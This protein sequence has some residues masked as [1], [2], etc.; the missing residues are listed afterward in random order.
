MAKFKVISTV[1][2]K[3]KPEKTV[4]FWLEEYDGNVMLIYRIE[5]EIERSLCYLDNEHKT[6]CLFSGDCANLGLE[7]I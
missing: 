2:S 4:E 3:K 6:A 7:K 5:G 1:D